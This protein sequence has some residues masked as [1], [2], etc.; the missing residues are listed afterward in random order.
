MNS[1]AKSSW[2]ISARPRNKEKNFHYA[3]LLLPIVLVDGELLE[4]SQFPM[5]A[6]DIPDVA[7]YASLWATKNANRTRDNKIFWVF[8]Q[9]NIRLG[10]NCRLRLLPTV[11]NSLRSFT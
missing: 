3:W 8:M 9:M 4:D 11:Y 1:Y 10:I 5:I 7:K 2:K 6:R